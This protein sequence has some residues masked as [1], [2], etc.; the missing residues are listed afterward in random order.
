MSYMSQ[1][2]P[3]ELFQCHHA[4]VQLVIATYF[5]LLMRPDETQSDGHHH[6]C[7]HVLFE[8]SSSLESC[9]PFPETILV[10]AFSFV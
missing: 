7:V 5:V 1:S 6:Q 10:V 3:N 2:S 4:H 9:F 8:F